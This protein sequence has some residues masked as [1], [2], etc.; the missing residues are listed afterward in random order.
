MF[1]WGP[2]QAQ[3]LRDSLS[4][5]KIQ[6]GSGRDPVHFLKARAAGFI[7]EDATLGDIWETISS[8]DLV[9]LLIFDSA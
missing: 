9:L 1:M 8:S 4:E 3:N 6:L 5:T 7:E 2:A